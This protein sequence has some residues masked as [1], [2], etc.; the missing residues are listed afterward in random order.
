VRCEGLSPWPGP[1]AILRRAE[2]RPEVL[3]SDPERGRRRARPALLITVPL[4]GVMGAVVGYVADGAGAAVVV[5][6][7]TLAGAL[8]GGWL[9]LR[10]EA[11]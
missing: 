8:L 9:Y 11:G 2:T 3:E 1:A 7:L 5:G 4:A 10:F 6:G